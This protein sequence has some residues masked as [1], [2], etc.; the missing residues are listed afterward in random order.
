MELAKFMGAKVKTV[1]GIR[2]QIKKSCKEGPE[3]SFR[4]TFEDKVL[5]SDI[6]IMNT[7]Y[8]IPLEKFYNPVVSFDE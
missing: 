5:M 1:S 4:A 7:W 3:G 2:G 6:V 8:P